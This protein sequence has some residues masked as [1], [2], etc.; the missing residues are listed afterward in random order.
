MVN[1]LYFK[2]HIIISE[3]PLVTPW[4]YVVCMAYFLTLANFQPKK[5]SFLGLK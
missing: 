4:Y 2:L 5:K 3:C 1:Q